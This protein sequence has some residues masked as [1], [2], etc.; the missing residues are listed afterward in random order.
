MILHFTVLFKTL[1]GLNDW[2]M[3]CIIKVL[4]I[5]FKKN[6]NVD[7]VTHNITPF[8]MSPQYIFLYT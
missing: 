8:L 7:A 3:F 6:K 1:V 4:Q 5:D 2:R